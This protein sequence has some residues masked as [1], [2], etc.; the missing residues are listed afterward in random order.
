[1]R[2]RRASLDNGFIGAVVCSPRLFLLGLLSLMLAAGG[3][4]GEEAPGPARP[5]AEKPPLPG[6]YT[7]VQDSDG[8]KPVPG[9]TITLVL[10][11]DGTLSLHA[12]RPGE[13][14]TDEGAYSV[15]DGRMTLEFVGQE[16]AASD[17]PYEYDGKNLE[18][19]VK[20]F[21]E[22][23]GSSTWRRTEAVAEAAPTE[24]A[25]AEEVEVEFEADW[26][27]W[28]LDKD[29]SAAAMKS[30]VEAV[31]EEGKSWEQAIQDA[32]QLARGF[33]DVAD[34]A[35]S[36]NGLNITILYEDDTEDYV[37]TERLS[38]TA[39]QPSAY[40][41][42]VSLRQASARP[43]GLEPSPRLGAAFAGKK[44]DALEG[45]PDRVYTVLTT[46]PGG[47]VIEE[48]RTGQKLEP[49]REGLGEPQS[50]PAGQFGVFDYNPSLQ[51][52]DYLA[53]DSPPPEARR[54][55]LVSPAYELAHPLPTGKGIEVFESF[56]DNVG[57]NI[58]CISEDLQAAGYTTDAID[59]ILGRLEGGKPVQ[60]G[61][62][63]VEELASLLTSKR[64]GV[65]YFMTHGSY[66]HSFLSRL[67]GR[68]MLLYLGLLDMDRP[69]LKKVVGNRK[70]DREVRQE[71]VKALASMTGLTWDKGQDAPFVVGSEFNGSAILWVAPAFFRMLREQKGASFDSSL[72]FVNACSSA[73][74]SSL[75]DAFAAKV[76]FGWAV[77]GNGQFMA[78]AAETV[79]DLLV[80]KA[81][82][83]RNAWW[84]WRIHEFWQVK[85]EGAER[86]PERDPENLK[87]IGADG[88]EY[89]LMTGQTVILI[90]RMRHGPSTATAQ[91]LASVGFI[92][93]CW[94]ERWSQGVRSALAS[95]ACFR[96]E[97][98]QHQPT[99]EEVDDAVFEVG[100]LIEK[101][102]G[103]WTLAD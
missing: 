23:P 37:P 66:S 17:A 54:A 64:Y 43:V 85:E 45:F 1:M 83:A 13:E 50:I 95:P 48:Q 9:A 47:E 92:E 31:T 84:M 63:A 4:G 98:G 88:T 21:S 61:D 73:A 27:L 67:L 82:S 81:R 32:A 79:F 77:S 58:E 35:V 74:D 26:D 80:D 71:I 33:P 18:I 89:P 65:I 90:Y 59:T 3:C 49:G 15:G 6:T 70:L 51:P 11:E 24:E 78:D 41:R 93:Q 52:A 25:K 96:L 87:A 56:K 7:L 53:K 75:R 30:I 68:P 14:L 29:A 57:P 42:P 39:S 102:F 91:V 40:R 2:H 86:P 44:C 94:E 103:R 36:G 38:F 5:E 34:V 12:V 100:G 101:P 22:G 72:V 76:Y 60:T 19:P 20:M 97:D 55:L 16:I 28:D 8:T 46:T 10:K 69:E 62:R 99:R